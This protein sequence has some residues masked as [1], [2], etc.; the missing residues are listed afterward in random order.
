MERAQ[1]VLDRNIASLNARDLDGYLANQCPDVEFVLPGGL[2]LRGRE[3]AAEYTQAL[4]RAFP[5]GS[6]AFGDPSISTSSR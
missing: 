3:Q 5:D 6:L 4:C 2:V 1:E